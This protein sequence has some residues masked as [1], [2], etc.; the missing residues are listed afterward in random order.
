LPSERDRIEVHYLLSYAPE[1]NP[2]ER[3]NADMKQAV[4]AK[5]PVR[6]KSKLKAA[7]EDH[8]T[9]IGKFPHRVRAYFQDP[10]V[11]YAA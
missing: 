3:L 5:I 1:L 6:T 9:M 10:R 7:V 8:M 11:K 2:D 4:G